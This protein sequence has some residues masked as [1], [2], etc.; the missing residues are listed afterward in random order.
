MT[1]LDTIQAIQQLDDVHDI[2][3][4]ANGNWLFTIATIDTVDLSGA[5]F[6]NGTNG[7][8]NTIIAGFGVQEVDANNNI[9]FEW[10]SNDHIPPTETYL[11]YGYNVSNFDYCHG[12]AVAEDSDGHLLLSFRH[13]NAIYKIHRTTGAIIWKL[14]GHTSDF[15]F[16]ND[17][18]FSGQHDIRKLPNG[19]YSLFNNANMA[20]APKVSKGKEFSLDT[21]NWT[22][23]L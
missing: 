14:G 13:L 9:V 16:T 19:N 2:Q 18:G 7:V 3:R 15:N 11:F 10:D 20:P 12:N 23:T 4:A 21:I 6:Y 8:A 5:T 17:P 22:A 1:I